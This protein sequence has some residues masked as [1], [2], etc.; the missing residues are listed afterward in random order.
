[1][2]IN[3]FVFSNQH[4]F[5]ATPANKYQQDFTMSSKQLLLFC[6]TFS[7]CVAKDNKSMV[8]DRT[9]Q[10]SQPE[11]CL[12]DA[13]RSEWSLE[14]CRAWCSG[15]L[16]CMDIVVT[17]DHFDQ[18][19]NYFNG[20]VA[21]GSQD[22]DV[23]GLRNLFE[24]EGL[25]DDVQQVAPTTSE[26]TNVL[27]IPE[28]GREAKVKEDLNPGVVEGFYSL[29]HEEDYEIEEQEPQY[30][31]DS[32]QQKIARRVRVSFTTKSCTK[33]SLIHLAILATLCLRFN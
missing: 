2:N 10:D 11:L 23:E 26:A 8:C 13:C 31:V 33:N 22:L 24:A 27:M 29:V 1:M 25:L 15:C 12:F 32:D 16:P 7:V 4:I 19:L 9:C 6:I 3:K 18:A 21:A 28:S 14:N 17:Q 5:L 30:F 20:I